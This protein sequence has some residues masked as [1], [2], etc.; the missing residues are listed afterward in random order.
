M[1]RFAIIE[2][3]TGTV[4]N[5][6]R[7]NSGDPYSPGSGKMLIQVREDTFVDRGMIYIPNSDPPAFEA[8]APV[9]EEVMPA[10]QSE[11]LD[12]AEAKLREGLAM[13]EAARALG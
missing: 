4:S 6:I 2:E 12:A 7:L 1:A 10:N 5:V 11:A 9:E 8:A 13:I 3:A